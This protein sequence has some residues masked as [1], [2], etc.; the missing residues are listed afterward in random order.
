MI[1]MIMICV[2]DLMN[3]IRFRLMVVLDL[4]RRKLGLKFGSFDN[5][6][7]YPN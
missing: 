4:V 3:I 5:E 2:M 1:V 7:A 6:E